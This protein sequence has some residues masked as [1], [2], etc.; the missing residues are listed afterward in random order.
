MY[1][2]HNLCLVAL[3]DNRSLTQDTVLIYNTDPMK[4]PTQC[5]DR[6]PGARSVFRGTRGE[7][8]PTTPLCSAVSGFLTDSLR[9]RQ[10]SSL[11]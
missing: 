9:Q 11:I 6:R 4:S 7:C 2:L 8:L 1:K 3:S 5:V 10:A